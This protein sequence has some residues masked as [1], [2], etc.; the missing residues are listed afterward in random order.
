LTDYGSDTKGRE[1]GRAEADTLSQLSGG[2]QGSSRHK[3]LSRLGYV[4]LVALA[5]LWGSNFPIM[6]IALREIPPW[7]FRTLCLGFGGL[8]VFVL[9]KAAGFPLA[10]PTRERKPLLLVAFLNVT[11]WNVCS[12]YAILHMEAGRVAIIAFTMP[13][14]AAIIGRYVLKE[15]LGLT[16][17]VGL[18][19]GILGLAILI[20]SEIKAFGSAP[21][22]AMFILGA[23]I[24]WAAGTVALKY[25]RWTMPTI[26]LAGWQLIAGGL[27]VIIGA[28]I[29]EPITALSEISWQGAL[30]TSYVIVLP[31][32]FCYWAWFKVVELFPAAVA[33]IGT[34]G[35]PVVGVFSSALV[36]GER[37]GFREL[38][39]LV[40]VVMAL[41][42]VMIGPEAVRRWRARF[43]G[44]YRAA[45]RGQG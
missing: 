10:I 30:A 7:T 14:W 24:S 9:A 35:I 44:R 5:L 31:V 3:K 29:L 17:L 20:G 40:L 1:K 4:L 36:L 33:A 34:L 28:L 26:I 11:G 39:A 16:R 22:G 25:F 18:C 2:S 42:I 6:K 41:A 8:G 15:R 21:L 27:P 45:G 37:V 43:G 32:I 19:L 12:A 23:A 38:A 13:V